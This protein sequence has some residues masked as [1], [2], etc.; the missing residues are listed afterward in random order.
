MKQ[1]KKLTA[2]EEKVQVHNSSMNPMNGVDI[3]SRY[4]V[5]IREDAELGTVSGYPI[6]RDVTSGKLYYYNSETGVSKWVE[7]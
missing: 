1:K 2:A 3:G 5:V 7:E 6:H 4:D